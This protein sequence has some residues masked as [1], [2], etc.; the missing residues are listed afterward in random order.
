MQIG[1]NQDV[2]HNGERY[3][4]QTEDGGVK[5]PVITTLLFKGGVVLASKKTPYDDIIKFDRLDTVVRELMEEQHNSILS[6]LRAGLFDES[7]AATANSPSSGTPPVGEEGPILE[8]LVSSADFLH[9][10]L[11]EPQEVDA[12]PTDTQ[13]VEDDG[14]APSE[15]KSLDDIILEH[16]SLK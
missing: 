9:T 12:P 4:I 11:E 15:K 1:I 16:L 6:D 14:A 13:A 2:E 5:N 7:S 8:G 10:S 3:H